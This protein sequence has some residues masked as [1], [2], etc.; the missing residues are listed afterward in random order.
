MKAMLFTAAAC[1]FAAALIGS[2]VQVKGFQGQA[3]RSAG[4]T[5]RQ[6]HRR[7]LAT[8]APEPPQH[9]VGTGHAVSFAQ[10]MHLLGSHVLPSSSRS[11]P[12][13]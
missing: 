9:F 2:A 6:T 12:T 4:T 1:T 3:G 11:T 8:K 13:R 5:Q 10:T 7:E